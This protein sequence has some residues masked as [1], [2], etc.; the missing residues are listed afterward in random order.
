MCVCVCVGVC[1]WVCVCACVRACVCM[2]ARVRACVRACV[3]RATVRMRRRPARC[4]RPPWR[5][6]GSGPAA[7]IG[8]VQLFVILRFFIICRRQYRKYGLIIYNF[9]REHF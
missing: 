7:D 4:S 8:M 9:F 1:V 5:A 6:G 2:C 3:W